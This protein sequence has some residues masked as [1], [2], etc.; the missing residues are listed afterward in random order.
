MHKGVQIS[1]EQ[2]RISRLQYCPSFKILWTLSSLAGKYL[3]DMFDQCTAATLQDPFQEESF[4]TICI[5]F[6]F[7]Q[8][9]GITQSS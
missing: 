2:S 6:F 4:I 5:S 1:K 9:G 7:K 3:F 8:K